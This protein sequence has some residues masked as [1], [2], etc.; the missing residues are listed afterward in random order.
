MLSQP[1]PRVTL[2]TRQPLLNTV[3]SCH[4]VVGLLGRT[5][6]GRSAKQWPYASARES[7]HACAVCR[8]WRIRTRYCRRRCVLG[9]GHFPAC[10]PCSSKVAISNLRRG[11]ASPSGQAKPSPR[12]GANQPVRC[13]PVFQLRKIARGVRPS[14]CQSVLR[15]STRAARSK[16]E[17]VVDE[18]YCG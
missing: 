17:P 18:Q 3:R 8:S 13:R 7:G 1:L 6:V 12:R 14:T 4:H 11:V 10:Y 16:T 15:C 9:R 2:A 5:R